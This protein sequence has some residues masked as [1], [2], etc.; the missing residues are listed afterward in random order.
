MI[1]DPMR[2]E[3]NRRASSSDWSWLFVLA[4]LL[5]EGVFEIIGGVF[6]VF[7]GL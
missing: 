7:S 1:H 4:E 6:E 3:I 5:F 2:D